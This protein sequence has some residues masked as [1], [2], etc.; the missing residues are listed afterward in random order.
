MNH[1]S[2]SG[3]QVLCQNHLNSAETS[4]G[5]RGVEI[6][7]TA[8]LNS[9]FSTLPSTIT[10]VVGITTLN[11]HYGRPLPMADIYGI[12]QRR[13]ERVADGKRR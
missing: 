1:L 4:M 11:V 9:W 3:G 12:H 13:Q 6:K 10:I 7:L 5:T 2:T 8:I